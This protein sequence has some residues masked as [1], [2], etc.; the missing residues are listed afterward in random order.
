MFTA[1]A[2]SLMQYPK[3][4]FLHAS[5]FVILVIVPVLSFCHIRG[6]VSGYTS[7]DLVQSSLINIKMY[8]RLSDSV[9]HSAY[10]LVCNFVFVFIVWISFGSCPN[11]FDLLQTHINTHTQILLYNEYINSLHV[12]RLANNNIRRTLHWRVSTIRVAHRRCKTLSIFVY[13]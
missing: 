12:L 1:I 5:R 8:L 7:L 13:Q 4:V 9:S 6:N 2:V 11:P 3:R 10:S